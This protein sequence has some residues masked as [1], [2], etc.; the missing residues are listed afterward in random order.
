VCVHVSGVVVE[1]VCSVGPSFGRTTNP[2]DRVR[3]FCGFDLDLEPLSIPTR[4][5]KVNT[6]NK[7]PLT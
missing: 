1:W 7:N 4:K 3:Y 5:R 6:P 2:P